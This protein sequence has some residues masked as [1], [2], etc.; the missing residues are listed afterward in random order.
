[1]DYIYKQILAFKSYRME[2]NRQAYNIINGTKS[3]IMTNCKIS[4]GG[5][6]A[7][8]IYI[9]TIIMWV[10]VCNFLINASN[11]LFENF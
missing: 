11:F 5:G 4:K 2:G 8:S 7:A 3:E 6:W 10:N 1:M 9:H